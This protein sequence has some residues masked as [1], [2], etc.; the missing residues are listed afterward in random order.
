MS[1]KT[2]KE[3]VVAVKDIAGRAN[4]IGTTLYVKARHQNSV[5]STDDLFP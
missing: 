4:E 2:N 5:P 1:H 3:A